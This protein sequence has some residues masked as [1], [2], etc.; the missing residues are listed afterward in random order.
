MSNLPITSNLLLFSDD[1]ALYYSDKCINNLYSIVQRDLDSVT[2]WLSFNKLCINTSKTKAT[3][4][5]KSFSRSCGKNLSLHVSSVAIKHVEQ[6]EYLG[7]IVDGKLSFK[8]QNSKC[9]RRA[10]NT[11]YQLRK[12]RGC[13]TRRCALSIKRW[14]YPCLNMEGCF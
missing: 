10:S 7:I 5:D 12:I 13:I 6:Y 14:C 3:I 4:F 9:S 11:I 1:T 2:N 8:H